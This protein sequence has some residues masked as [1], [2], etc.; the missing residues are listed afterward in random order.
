[1]TTE[2]DTT[3]HQTEEDPY[4]DLVAKEGAIIMVEVVL[5]VGLVGAI[6]MV[7][8]VVRVD[9]V[10]AII[11]VGVVL[12]VRVGV[13]AMVGMVGMGITIISQPNLKYHQSENV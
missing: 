8:V 5:R 7:E 9:L 10:G 2:E 11:M 13:A 3:A 4:S 12:V 1:M 6:I